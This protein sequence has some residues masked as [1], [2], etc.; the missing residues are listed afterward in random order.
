MD[1]YD[2]FGLSIYIR[3]FTCPSRVI[4]LFTIILLYIIKVS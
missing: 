4:V 2:T 3:V 1:T